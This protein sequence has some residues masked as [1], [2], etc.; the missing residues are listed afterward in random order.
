MRISLIVAVARNGVI[1]NDGEIPWR[2]PED[3]K[4]FRRATMGQALVYG[5]KTFDSIGKAL[6]GR[7][8]FVL[9]RNEH[10][11]VEGV[12]FV[13]DLDEAIERARA[14]GYDECFVA[15]GEAIYR[16]A[17][18]TADRVLRTVVDAEPEGDTFFPP[19]DPADWICT[20]R[21]PHDVDDRHAHAFVIETWERRG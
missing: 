7:A 16:A 10:A 15:G 5:R 9:T 3:Q 4:F 1:G 12:D 19:L 17:L 13:A 11:P 14:A 20:G 8:N 18:A 21:V 2:L 6:P